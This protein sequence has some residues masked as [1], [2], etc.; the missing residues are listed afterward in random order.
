MSL[1]FSLLPLLK[2]WNNLIIGDNTLFYF[3]LKNK[4]HHL[5]KEIKIITHI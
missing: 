5:I 3:T 4:R 2:F 1:G